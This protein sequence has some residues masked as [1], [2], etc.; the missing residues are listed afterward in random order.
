MHKALRSPSSASLC[1]APSPFRGKAFIVLHFIMLDQSYQR[2]HS[3]KA[4]SRIQPRPV[5][6]DSA[7]GRRAGEARPKGESRKRTEESLL[8]SGRFRLSPATERG[9]SAAFQFL[10]Q[11]LSRPQHRFFVSFLTQERNVFPFVPPR[12]PRPFSR[13]GN[14]VRPGGIHVK[15]RHAVDGNS[16]VQRVIG[17]ERQLARAALPGKGQ[18]HGGIARGRVA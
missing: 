4:D 14:A 9:S 13:Q 6:A 8:S 12:L 3:A 17:V 1:S 5:A 7:A 18:H 2:S 16:P 10:F 11:Q 15:Q